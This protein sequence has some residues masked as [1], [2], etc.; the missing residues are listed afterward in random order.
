MINLMQGDCL[1]RMKEIPS[2]SV[3]MVLVDPP[4]GTT[5]CK[6]DSVIDL[7]KMWEQISR[8][9]K[10]RA[11]IVFTAAQPFTSVLVCSNIKLFK[12]DLVWEKG[13]ATGFLNAKKMPL[14]AHESILVFYNK[15]P[16]FN[17]QMTHGHE[18]K[19]TKRR[20]V[21]SEC[22]GEAIKPQGYDS[23]SRYPRS[24]KFISSD[25]QKCSFH[26]TQ[27]PVK[28]MEYLIKTYTNESETVL[29]FTMGSGSTGVACKNLNRKFIG[30]EKDLDY[31]NVAL[32]RIEKA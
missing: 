1:E 9:A 32:D 28:L 4:Y 14:R 15:L 22:Y 31:F 19:V 29:D 8:V 10:E 6:W 23:T 24:V 3:D 20:D 11:A 27:K 30:I 5:K 21:N 17:P 16:K 2:G 7:N 26:P 18:R 25:K 13:N 12:Y